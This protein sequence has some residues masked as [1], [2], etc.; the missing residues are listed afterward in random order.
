[1]KRIKK[2]ISITLIVSVCISVAVISTAAES[3]FICGDADGDGTV[4]VLDATTIQRKLVQLPTPSF[5]EKA[6][7]VDGNG[8]DITDA[9]KIQRYLA[10]FDDLYHIGKF[11]SDNVQPTQDEYELPFVPNSLNHIE[12]R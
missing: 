4:T 1:M 6:A 10:E 11:V 9:T 7:D 8:L 5:S 3:R 2:I 12:N